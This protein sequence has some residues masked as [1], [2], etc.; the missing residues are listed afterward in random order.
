MNSFPESDA[1]YSKKRILISGGTGF[2]GTHLLNQLQRVGADV[3]IISRSAKVQFSEIKVFVG[4]IDDNDFVTKT[5]EEFSPQIIFHLA[6]V[7][8]R[9][10]S[11]E[12]FSETIQ[13]NLIGS[14]NL[15]YASLKLKQL[16][17]FVV[18][19]TAEE[20]GKNLAPFNEKMR[21]SSVSAYSFSKQSVTHLS[22]L[23]YESFELPTVVL[24]PSI[25]Y[26]PGQNK[27]MF[28][29]ALLE[30]LIKN[31]PFPMTHGEQTRDFVY[32]DD[33]VQAILRAGHYPHLEGEV[34]NIG[35]GKP[36]LIS[37]LVKNV[38]ELLHV[39]GLAQLGAIPYRQTEQM[40]Y[41]LDI[42]KAKNLL[43]WGNL[44][45]LD[46]G[47]KRTISWHKRYAEK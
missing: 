28:L 4:S 21:E 10:L 30:S 3:A 40:N 8:A 37:N 17:R 29:P 22:Q 46:E 25:A 19:G 14:L 9:T 6:A 39:K 34:I 2:I 23:M 11:Y 18:L 42:T 41:W 13:S 27:D 35:S 32:I 31:K 38:E 44:T 33:L 20:Y 7:R 24:R 26:G 36:I 45:T 16:K 1:F 47:L 43:G 12:A 15:L 5:V